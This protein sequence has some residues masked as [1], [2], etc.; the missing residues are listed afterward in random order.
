VFGNNSKN[1]ITIETNGMSALVEKGRENKICKVYSSDEFSYLVGKKLRSR[2]FWNAL[3]ENL[4]TM[5][6]GY[7]SST[8]SNVSAGYVNSAALAANNNGSV[9]GAVGTSYGASANYSKTNS[10]NGAAQYQA[11]QIARQ[12]TQQYDNQLDQY[13]QSLDAGYLKSNVVAP[14][15]SIVGNVNIA[16]QKGDRLSFYVSIEGKSYSF[17]W[18]IKK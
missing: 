17:E 18:S 1:P 4:A 3:G 5:N 11:N 6:A 7:S 16:Y 14:G 15:Q 10:Y 8:T 2:S 13:K 12:N 9:A